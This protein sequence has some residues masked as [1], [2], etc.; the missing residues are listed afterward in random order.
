M[1]V[2]I[3]RRHREAQTTDLN[4]QILMRLNRRKDQASTMLSAY[5]AKYTISHYNMSLPIDLPNCKSAIQC[6][7]AQ[8]HVTI[9]AHLPGTV[10]SK[11]IKLDTQYMMIVRIKRVLTSIRRIRTRQNRKQPATLRQQIVRSLHV[12]TRP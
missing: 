9:L 6:D 2:W 8:G 5:Q 7:L 12:K 4:C 10:P 1:T 11:T 3:S